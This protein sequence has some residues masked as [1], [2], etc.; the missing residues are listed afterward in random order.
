[1]LV[2]KEAPQLLFATLWTKTKIFSLFIFFFDSADCLLFSGRSKGTSEWGGMVWKAQENSNYPF[3]DIM[4]SA[5]VAVGKKRKVCVHVSKLRDC[6]P[7][8]AHVSSGLIWQVFVVA[9]LRTVPERWSKKKTTKKII[10]LQIKTHSSAEEK[11]GSNRLPHGKSDFFA[12]CVDNKQFFFHCEV[13]FV[14]VLYLNF[15]SWLII[16]QWAAYGVKGSL[17]VYFFRII[18][19]LFHHI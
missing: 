2:F 3:W 16:A 7:W 10:L 15:I 4:E 11:K 9:F 17:R 13:F 19:F 1:M 14:L 5:E 12:N 18:L 6:A 8:L